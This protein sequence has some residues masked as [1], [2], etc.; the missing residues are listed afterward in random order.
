MKVKFLKNSNFRFTT[1]FI[2]FKPKDSKNFTDLFV[3]FA[4]TKIA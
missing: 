4:N 3:K 2:N 1:K